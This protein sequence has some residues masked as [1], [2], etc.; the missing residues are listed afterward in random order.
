MTVTPSDVLPVGKMLGRYTSA[1]H[2]VGERQNAPDDE[3]FAQQV[4]DELMDRGGVEGRG[5]KPAGR[6][7]RGLEGVKDGA[8]PRSYYTEN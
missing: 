8:M 3:V 6:E 5:S 7:R 2:D 1:R 4:L